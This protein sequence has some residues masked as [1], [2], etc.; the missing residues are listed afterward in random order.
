MRVT[1]NILL[2]D[3]NNKV[4][5]LE[6]LLIY[7]LWF[8][9]S[10]FFHIR[11][12]QALVPFLLLTYIMIACIIRKLW[13]QLSTYPSNDP[14]TVNWWQLMVNVRV[15][16][17]RCAFSHILTFIHMWLPIQNFGCKKKNLSFF[18]TN[19]PS[20]NKLIRYFTNC[21]EI[22]SEDSLDIKL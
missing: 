15:G 14:T 17:G 20:L 7:L 6:E 11:V 10:N 2:T 19:V 8:G 3:S 4:A 5:T 1:K 12:W 13:E 9:Y 21:L 16:E 22:W 18:S